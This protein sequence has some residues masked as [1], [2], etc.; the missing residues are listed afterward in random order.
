MIGK[1]KYALMEY[2]GSTE[3]N[4]MKKRQSYITDRMTDSD[5]SYIRIA[6]KTFLACI[7]TELVGM[8][9]MFLWGTLGTQMTIYAMTFAVAWFVARKNKNIL[10]WYN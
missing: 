10:V 1:N 4:G 5:R 8:F 6:D 9:T 3:S 2:K 7:V